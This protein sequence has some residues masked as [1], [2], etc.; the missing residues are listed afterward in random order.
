MKVIKCFRKSDCS[1]AG[2]VNQLLFCFDTRCSG[3]GRKE[4]SQASIREQER[5][6]KKK[7]GAIKRRSTLRDDEAC[8]E[9][10]KFSEERV[11]SLLRELYK[12]RRSEARQSSSELVILVIE[13]IWKRRQSSS[14]HKLEA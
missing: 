14:G 2:R 9:A 11:I 12:A 4:R 7:G 5:A 3:A 6:Q 13:R 10:E 1:E 8:E